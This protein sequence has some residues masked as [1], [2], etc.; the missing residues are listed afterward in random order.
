MHLDQRPENEEQVAVETGE[1]H[2]ALSEVRS[3][4]Q[5]LAAAAAAQTHPFLRGSGAADDQRRA[6]E[7]AQEL[8]QRRRERHGAAEDLERPLFAQVAADRA[9]QAEERAEL[10]ASFEELVEL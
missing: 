1:R 5:R 6:L 9:A 8:E 7:E 10:A 2:L 3:E 4:G